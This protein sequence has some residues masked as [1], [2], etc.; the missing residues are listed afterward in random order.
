M[1]PKWFP[2]IK[3]CPILE[4]LLSGLKFKTEG[5][6]LCKQGIRCPQKQLFVALNAGMENV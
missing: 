3:C 4:V 6:P 5:F 2:S 1:Q